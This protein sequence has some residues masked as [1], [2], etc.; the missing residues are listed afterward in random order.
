MDGPTT[1]S[2][3]GRA[4]IERVLASEASLQSSNTEAAQVCK[5]YQVERTIELG[6]QH[7]FKSIAL[8]FP[9]ELLNVSTLIANHLRRAL[10]RDVFILADTSYG[11]CCVDEVAA[12]HAS[13]DFVVHYGRAC[14]SPTRRLPVQYA[15]GQATIN[16]DNV[17]EKLDEVFQGHSDKH[18]LLMYDVVYAYCIDSLRSRLS[19]KDWP[20]LV[21]STVDSERLTNDTN[22]QSGRQYTLT[23]GTSSNDY[24]LFYIGGESLTLT[25]IIITHP[26]CPV[27]A[28]NPDTQQ[29]QPQ[30]S[31]VNRLLNRRFHF[32]VYQREY[33]E[34][35]VL[36]P[37]FVTRYFM[38]QKAKD[39]DVFG[40]VVGTLGVASYLP[41]IDHLKSLIASRSK[42]SYTLAVGK[43]NP[44]KLGNFMEIE[45]FVLVAC[46]ENSLIDSKEFLRPIVTPFEL[47]LALTSS[48]EWVGRDLAY[49]T[50]LEVMRERLEQDLTVAK[51]TNGG[52]DEVREDDDGEGGAAPHFSLVTGKY[53]QAKTYIASSS[54][55]PAKDGAVDDDSTM[56]LRNQNTALTVNSGS[57]AAVEYLQQRTYQGLDARIGQ[58]EA[59]DVIEGR[60]GIARG[61]VGEA[62]KLEH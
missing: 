33:F 30:S 31:Q 15:F 13:A 52:G 60:S 46:P 5:L 6:R 8:Q 20:N 23:K 62:E 38:L 55:Q 58:T 19:G 9:D 26:S 49:V 2:D 11:S 43:P 35:P 32:K 14:L 59:G 10:G 39:A 17:V 4:V 47:E 53:K 16:L 37:A 29:C 42:K 22:V 18:V 61:Y 1:F 44:A 27:I 40:I 7:G 51:D 25:N 21:I 36:R 57:S 24:T 48:E 3:D 12:E 54:H 34:S 41:V 45:C 56:V 50:D 28:Y